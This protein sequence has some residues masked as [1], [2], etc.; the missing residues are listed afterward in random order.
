MNRRRTRA[1]RT[2]TATATATCRPVRRISSTNRSGP[3]SRFTTSAEMLTCRACRDKLCAPLVVGQ[4]PRLVMRGV[5][6]D[7]AF[8]DDH[9][10][11]VGI[12]R[13]P[14]QSPLQA[15][16]MNRVTSAVRKSPTRSCRDLTCT[17]AVRCFHTSGRRTPS[18]R[19]RHAPTSPV[20]MCSAAHRHSSGRSQQTRRPPPWLASARPRS[21]DPPRSVSASYASTSSPSLPRT[22]RPRSRPRLPNLPN[23]AAS[24]RPICAGNTRSCR[25]PTARRSRRLRVECH[26][27]L[28]RML[29]HGVAKLAARGFAA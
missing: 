24:K 11:L 16:T 13:G 27:A 25:T 17:C 8:D 18:A 4:V 3:P 15:W 9:G 29:M 14:E 2:A 10:G 19:T 6:I 1:R 23:R 26:L 22:A 7:G 5:P 12:G 20:R 21:P 28:H